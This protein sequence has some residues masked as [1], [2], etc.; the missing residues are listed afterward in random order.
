MLDLKKKQ[1]ELMR[2]ECAK[3]EMQ[4]K[5]LEIKQNIKRLEA[6]IVIQDKKIQELSK[7]I[8]NIKEG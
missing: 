6:N 2:V 4:M 7:E 8:N 1:V 3:A 5:I